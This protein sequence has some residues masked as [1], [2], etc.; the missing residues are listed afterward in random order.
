[1]S[2]TSPPPRNRGLIELVR[3]RRRAWHRWLFPQPGKTD[4]EIAGDQAEY[5][6]ALAQTKAAQ[7]PSV[8]A[9]GSRGWSDVTPA[10]WDD[11]SGPPS[12]DITGNDP[13]RG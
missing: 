8:T 1:M 12:E 5:E 7:R 10:D 6:A 11:F 4:E 2:D 13:W 9:W 3:I